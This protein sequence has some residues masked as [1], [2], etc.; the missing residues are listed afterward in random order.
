MVSLRWQEE[1]CSRS[2]VNTYLSCDES[3]PIFTLCNLHRLRVSA[4]CPLTPAT[5]LRSLSMMKARQQS[6]GHYLQSERPRAFALRSPPSIA[7]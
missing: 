3:Q 6:E 5:S 7:T 2:V 4:S 1:G